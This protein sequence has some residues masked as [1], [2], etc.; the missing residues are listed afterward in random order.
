MFLSDRVPKKRSPAR[1]QARLLSRPIGGWSLATHRGAGRLHYNRACEARCCHNHLS[2]QSLRKRRSQKRYPEPTQHRA[3]LRGPT[4]FPGYLRFLCV[5]VVS[6]KQRHGSHNSTYNSCTLQTSAGYCVPLADIT[7]A[8]SLYVRLE[9]GKTLEPLLAGVCA[10]LEGG[11]RASAQNTHRLAASRKR[12]RRRAPLAG[13]LSP[14]G[15]TVTSM[16]RP[17]KRACKAA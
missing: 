7:F 15:T 13:S 10:A 3:K 11:I 2:H 9:K 14:P 1:D 8:P 5:A 12:P 4:V 16:S 17:S 6:A